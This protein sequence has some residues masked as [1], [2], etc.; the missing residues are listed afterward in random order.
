M[1]DLNK[2]TEEEFHLKCA[3]ELYSDVWLLLE[4]KGRTK[5]E[6]DAMITTAHASLY[7]WSKVG[8]PKNIATGHWQ[9]SRVYA[10]L[11]MPEQ[12]LYHAERCLAICEEFYIPD[13]DFERSWAYEA[14]AGAYA[15]KAQKAKEKLDKRDPSKQDVA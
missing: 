13:T 14:I 3:A 12:A 11:K 10:V 6:A 15:A 4:K 2:F 5:E 9:I 7:H 1:Q 8:K